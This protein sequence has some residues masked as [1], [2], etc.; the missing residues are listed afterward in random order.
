MNYGKALKYYREE[1]GYSVQYIADFLK[2]KNSRYKS[3]ESNRKRP[4]IYYIC[5]LSILLDFDITEF[6]EMGDNLD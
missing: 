5:K 2:M 3:M 1:N 6:I 4:R